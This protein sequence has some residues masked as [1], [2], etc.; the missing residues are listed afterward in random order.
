MRTKRNNANALVPFI[1]IDSQFDKQPNSNLRKHPNNN[2][3][4]CIY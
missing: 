2:L 1:L 3:T 4:H